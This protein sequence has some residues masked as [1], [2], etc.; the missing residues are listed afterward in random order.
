MN[1]GGGSIEKWPAVSAN[2]SVPM[3]NTKCSQVC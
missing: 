2:G 3:V 1:D